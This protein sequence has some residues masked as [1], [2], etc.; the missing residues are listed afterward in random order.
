MESETHTKAIELNGSLGSKDLK[1]C[2]NICLSGKEIKS[3]TQ[4][5]IDSP[6]KYLI[7]GIKD[8]PPIYITIIC[9]IQV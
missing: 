7:Y 4:V 6:P 5:D 1:N 8:S 3:E 2:E 9:G